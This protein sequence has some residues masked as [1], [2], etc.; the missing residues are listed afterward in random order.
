MTTVASMNVEQKLQVGK[1]KKAAGDELFRK[2]DYKGG[3]Y[4][5]SHIYLGV[6][7]D[8]NAALRAYHEVRNDQLI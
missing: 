8:V 1:D 6:I 2:G 3:G 7:T 4:T 5:C